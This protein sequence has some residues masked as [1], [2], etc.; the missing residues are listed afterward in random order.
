MTFLVTE[1]HT[2]LKINLLNRDVIDQKG[3]ERK[4]KSK[5]T[6]KRKTCKE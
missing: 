3:I 5:T 4:I 1:C 6:S 2:K